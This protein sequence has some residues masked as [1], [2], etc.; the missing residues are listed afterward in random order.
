MSRHDFVT[1]DPRCGLAKDTYETEVAKIIQT[2]VSPSTV[3]ALV[4]NPDIWHNDYLRII[5]GIY[6]YIINESRV[7]YCISSSNLIEPMTLYKVDDKLVLVLS[8]EFIK[9]YLY[10]PT[11]VALK[12][13]E[14]L[15]NSY[16]PPKKIIKIS[17]NR[18]NC[19]RDILD[20]LPDPDE[21]N[22]KD[23]TIEMFLQNTKASTDNYYTRTT[24]NSKTITPA[25]NVQICLLR[26][27]IL[28]D[29]AAK[30][31]LMYKQNKVPDY[32]HKNFAL[33]THS[34]HVFCD[35][36]I[37]VSPNEDIACTISQSEKDTNGLLGGEL[38]H[39]TQIV[40]KN[41][42]VKNISIPIHDTNAVETFL[43]GNTHGM[44]ND[45]DDSSDPLEDY[46]T[47][48]SCSDD[49]D[50]EDDVEDTVRNVA[51]STR[52]NDAFINTLD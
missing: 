26:C 21:T 12:K 34:K 20:L 44:F 41:N 31:Y 24:S 43:H 45:D 11:F 30:H 37:T 47:G 15:P 1:R 8:I 48:N 32:T 40:T 29:H 16:V 5:L 2:H 3:T 50:D 7:H 27:Y 39:K 4:K 17:N 49:D 18:P 28:A 13:H 9:M 14:L 23:N 38:R 42:T 33:F 19:T 6:S 46:Y 10:S 36:L 52:S 35:N 51:G 25:D 22:D